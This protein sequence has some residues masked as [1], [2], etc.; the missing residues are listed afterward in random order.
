MTSTAPA[1]PSRDYTELPHVLRSALALGVLQAVLVVL[2][3]IVSRAWSG[4]LELIAELI[5][6]I[7][8]VGATI[9]LPG[10]W[11]RAE[12]IEG[13]AGAAGIGLAATAVFLAFDLALLQPLGIYT[14]RWHQIGG[15]SNW[16]Y[17]P[18]WWMV[19]TYLA[20]LGAWV[21]ANQTAKSGSPNVATLAGGTFLIAAIVMVAAKVFGFPGAQL[22]VGTFSVAIL[23]ALALMALITGLGA[24]RP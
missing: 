21:R 6:V 24:R 7:V 15:G 19:G 1:A 2:F 22:G 12:T 11:T 17:H 16:W 9:V 14:N 10:V 23:P 5:I 18:V 13:I 3:A 4:P 20:W 8:G